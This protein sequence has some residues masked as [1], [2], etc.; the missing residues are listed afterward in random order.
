M[1]LVSLGGFTVFIKLWNLDPFADRN[2]KLT[3]FQHLHHLLQSALH[4][5]KVWKHFFYL[6]NPGNLEL[7]HRTVSKTSKTQNP[8]LVE[9]Q[10]LEYLK[11]PLDDLKTIVDSQIIIAWMIWEWT[12]LPCTICMCITLSI[13]WL[14]MSCPLIS[15]WVTPYSLHN[16]DPLTRV[17]E[18]LIRERPSRVTIVSVPV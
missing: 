15:P 7:S 13:A 6:Q 14:W 10:T 17:E 18:F 11:Q 12:E 1:G 2:S 4:K 9:P 16:C 8:L 5:S 3:M